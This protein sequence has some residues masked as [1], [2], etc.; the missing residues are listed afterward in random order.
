MIFEE[1]GKYFPIA[2]MKR[3]RH[4]YRSFYI[5]HS[6]VMTNEHFR[7]MHDAIIAGDPKLRTLR[8]L[9]TTVYTEYANLSSKSPPRK[10][11]EAK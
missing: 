10:G 9:Y 4:A 11:G 8:S 3:A 6:G 2:S 5:K 1:P 7:I